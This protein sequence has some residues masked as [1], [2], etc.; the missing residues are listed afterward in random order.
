MTDATGTSSYTDDPF[1]KLTSTTNGAGQVT[2]YGYNP[3]GQVTS[4]TYPLPSTA[5]WATSDNVSY[6]YDNADRLT[7]ITDF[8]G[9]TITFTNTADGLPSSQTLGST[10]GTITTS[11]DNADSP[12]A[13]A[14]KNSTTTLQS[15]AYADAPSG[16]ILTETD[17][18]ASTTSP[19]TYTYDVQGRII[20]MTPGTGPQL[21]YGFDASAN[22]TTLPNGATGTYDHAG[23]LTATALS[24]S[25]TNYTY[26]AAGERLTATRSG[27]TVASGTWNGARQLSAYASSAANM[28]SAT[29]DGEG[30]RA[31][32]TVTPS[33]GSASAQ[34]FV[35]NATTT[36]SVPQLL[37]DS[38]FAYLYGNRSTPV[39]QVNLSTGA[40]SYLVSDLLGSVRGIVGSSGALTAGTSYDAWG[41]PQTAGG[42][43][44]Y[45]PF[46]FAGGYTDP[47]G[48]IY[49]INRYYDPSTGQFLSIDALV[50]QTEEP[51]GYAGGDPVRS[52]DP[53][54]N[55][56]SVEWATDVFMWQAT[57]P[58]F[59]FFR[60]WW[61]RGQLPFCAR[62]NSNNGRALNWSSDQC[63]P[64][65]PGEQNPLGMP[66]WKACERHDFGYRNYKGQHRFTG[67]AKDRIDRNLLN[68]LN[69]YIC[70][71][72]PWWL[73]GICHGLAKTYYFVVHHI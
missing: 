8:T 29:Y 56:T 69:N 17:T 50:S 57:L 72:Q 21:G 42:L 67:A 20:S 23:E 12:S 53:T 2:G 52:A 62:L 24:G 37:M 45:T 63:S 14:L 13:I 7:S 61:C 54:G 31:A 1:G 47:T 9:K 51:Y 71:Y 58:G 28:T 64:R 48:L 59:Q 19:A 15:F 35:W 36:G 68:D 25:T 44:S 10:G 11:Y 73:K 6:G 46:G 49:L 60:N 65:L 40:P 34:A 41:N 27:T 33:G 26:S 22:L 5:T 4:I 3:D 32:A 16:D 30:L 18:P 66:F 70:S 38:G 55:E 39:E 43:A